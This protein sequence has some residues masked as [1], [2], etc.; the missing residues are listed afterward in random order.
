[1]EKLC[2]ECNATFT[3]RSKSPN[4]ERFCGKRCY[5]K[6]WNRHTNERLHP[7][8]LIHARIC[9]CCG[10]EFTP[11]RQHPFAKTCSVKCSQRRVALELAAKRERERDTSSRPCAECGTEFVR[12]K[13]SAHKNIYCS[14][15]CAV[16]VNHRIFAERHPERIIENGKKSNRR[17]WDG[18][19][20]AALERDG[21]KC[22]QCG[23][24]KKLRVHHRDGSGEAESP[25]HDLQNLETLCSTCHKRIHKLSYRVIDGVV[26]ISGPVF[27]HLGITIVRMA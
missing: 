12:S 11:D 1:M 25:N 4:R 13:Y 5:Q 2:D 3:T 26:V 24:E 6:F 10:V 21:R 8:K 23:A 20:A 15:R 17:R 9:A 16:R 27:E 22:I 18:N 14:S 7:E 19:H